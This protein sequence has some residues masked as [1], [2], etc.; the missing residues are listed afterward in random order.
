MENNRLRNEIAKIVGLRLDMV[1]LAYEMM[2]FNFGDYS[3]HTQCLTRI[4]KNNDILVTTF[5]YQSW[6]G[7]ESENNDEWYNLARFKAEIEGGKVLSAEVSPLND[8][9]IQMDNG[10]KLQ[11]LISNS[12]AHYDS[13]CEQYR[14]F[15]ASEEQ[16]KQDKPRHIVVYNKHIV[17]E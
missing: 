9:D 8:I 13:E 6:D 12:Y 11:I 14:F 16:I 5:D 3:L 10:V 15:N 7:E 2:I 17:I 4:I 1:H